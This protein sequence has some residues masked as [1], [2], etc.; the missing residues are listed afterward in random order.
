MEQACPSSGEPVCN[1]FSARFGGQARLEVF[2][3]EGRG[4]MKAFG[5]RAFWTAFALLTMVLLISAHG[6]AH[7]AEHGHQ[8]RVGS[9]LEFLVEMIPH[10]Q[11]AVDS[12]NLLLAVT[13]REEM[14]DFAKAVVDVQTREIA[15]MRQ[16]IE[17]WHPGET[18][19]PA[20][21]PM[22]RELMGL[23]PEDADIVFLED[24]IEH[25]LAAVHMAKEVLDKNLAQHDEVRTLAK[26]I[27]ATQSR[28]I[29]QMREWLEMWRGAPAPAGHHGH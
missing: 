29:D 1:G 8:H 26:E 17:Q 27:I 16:W 20:Y 4:R 12:A 25:H 21:Q 9:E 5:L 14:R 28:E 3:Q 6:A 15:M 22:M 24:M 18:T 23:S 10:H 7:A 2:K 13:A 11:E 19:Q